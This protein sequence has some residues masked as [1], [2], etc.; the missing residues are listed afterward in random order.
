MASSR[1][2][3]VVAIVRAPS[4]EACVKAAQRTLCAGP[5]RGHAGRVPC[6]L[7]LLCGLAS[8]VKRDKQVSVILQDV[9]TTT[10]SGGDWSR[11][12]RVASG[13][14]QRAQEKLLQG[15]ADLRG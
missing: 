13:G 3:K 7:R 10:S 11:D 5:R 14:S 8:M 9:E 6:Q 15:V 12:T 4:G 2:V 1:L